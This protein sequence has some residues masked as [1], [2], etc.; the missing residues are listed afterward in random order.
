[1]KSNPAPPAGAELHRPALA[2]GGDLP[3]GWLGELSL[4]FTLRA[5]R[6]VL[7]RRR[8]YGPF[9]VQRPFYPEPDH[10]HLYL[11]HPPGGVVG[12]DRLVL[13]VELDAGS[14]ALL[15]MPGATKY[16]RS[17]GAQARL[18][19][20]FTL[21][22]GSTLEWL[23]PGSIFFP[24]AC[25]AVD[26]EFVL[27]AGA[28][29]LGFDLLCLGRPV[30]DEPFDS[31]TLDSRLRIAIDGSPGLRERLRIA[32]GEMDKLGGYALN[33]TFFASPADESMLEP[34]R[35]LLSGAG[36]PA[37]GATLLDSLLV[38]RLLDNDNQR[39]QDVLHRIWIM[40]RPLIIGRD[41]VLPRIWA[42]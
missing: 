36:V 37:A 16:Y 26:S 20:R 7:T 14:H 18:I 34:V 1:M 32:A 3:A 19:Q 15:T 2:D 40:L 30:N 38:V 42:T 39:L 11:L 9:T 28:R 31:G 33:A 8:H 22:A 13:D 41:A 21:H 6:T 29:L 27:H 25:V 23:P 4:G 17:E 24:G 10:P 5:G 12:G 35:Q